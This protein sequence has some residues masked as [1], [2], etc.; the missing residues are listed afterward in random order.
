MKITHNNHPSDNAIAALNTLLICLLPN[1]GTHRYWALIS[2]CGS[3]QQ[4]LGTDPDTLPILNKQ[5]RLLLHEYQCT[6]HNSR[7][8]AS[9]E[10]IIEQVEL[11]QSIIISVNNDGYP[12]LLSTIH[13]PPPLLYC[14]GNPLA[15]H[16]PQLAIV[17]SRHATHQGMNASRLFA[18][19][20]AKCGFSIT[21]GLA[22]GIDVAA[23]QAVL[24]TDISGINTGKTIAVMAT[25][26][27]TIY[28]RQH[29]RIAEQIVEN[30]GVLVTEFPPHTPPK[31][32]HFPRRN[33]IISGLSLGV[34]VVE[35]AIKSG[36]L[37]T[38]KYALEQGRE[39]YAI[40]SSIH[41][42]Q[43][44]GCHQLI[45]QGANLI[46]S[47]EDI[48]EHLDGMIAH[49]HEELRQSMHA[50][51]P[52]STERKQTTRADLTP[53]DKQLLAHLGFAPISIDQLIEASPLSSAEISDALL[54]LEINGWIKHSAWGYERV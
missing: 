11:S 5:A 54:D 14:K 52:E 29:L 23:H 49:H 1:I 51:D 32:G 10:A 30:D 36:S 7:L 3:E 6:P 33:R 17:G 40:P 19:H 50:S 39:V 18:Q 43:A 28:P 48:I 38:A 13:Q 22:L 15:L 46:E 37:I 20:L 53:R 27:N 26:I 35:A 47:S 44:K 4:I 8:M 9:A 16:L 12:S 31:A 21:S 25:G 24:N 41:N 45:K 2:H 42:P 34:I